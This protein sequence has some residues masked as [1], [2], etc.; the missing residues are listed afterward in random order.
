MEDT[1]LKEENELTEEKTMTESKFQKASD[2]IC[3]ANGERIEGYL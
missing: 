3:R 1:D 2:R